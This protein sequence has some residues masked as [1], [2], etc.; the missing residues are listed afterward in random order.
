MLFP[1]AL[2]SELQAEKQ[3]LEVHVDKLK[4]TVAQL[5]G[6]VQELA[7]RERLLVAFPELNPLP[8]GPPQSRAHHVL[9]FAL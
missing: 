6:E 7:K 1:Q 4:C 9:S 8:Q 3:R 2:C 5:R